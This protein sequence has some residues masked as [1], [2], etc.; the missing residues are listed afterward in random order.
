MKK[1]IFLCIAVFAIAGC[2]NDDDGTIKPTYESI[3]GIWYPSKIIKSDGSIVD[4]VGYCPSKR[5]YIEIFNY[6]TISSFFYSG[7]C[8]DIN[9]DN[10]CKRFYIDSD[11][12]EIT[13]CMDYLN[14][15]VT[16]KKSTLRIDYDKITSNSSSN[17]YDMKALIFTKE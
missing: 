6:L 9:R 7:N 8:T 12:N 4:Y 1:I 10:G 13:N 5:D 17:L 16:L 15:K 2:S 3:A 11:T 14:G